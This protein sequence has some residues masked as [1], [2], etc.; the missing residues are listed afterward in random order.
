MRALHSRFSQIILNWAQSFFDH[1]LISH[2]VLFSSGLEQ[3][4]C[5]QQTSSHG[6]SVEMRLIRWSLTQSLLNIHFVR[7][8]GVWYSSSRISSPSPQVFLLIQNSPVISRLL[9]FVFKSFSALRICFVIINVR[10]PRS[11]E[12]HSRGLLRDLRSFLQFRCPELADTKAT[13]MTWISI[14]FQCNCIFLDLL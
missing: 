13:T 7:M 6:L 8:N 5:P 3:D 4:D 11:L 14:P 12:V 1:F 10:M 2:Q 9:E